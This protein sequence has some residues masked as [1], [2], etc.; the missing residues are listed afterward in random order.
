MVEGAMGRVI[1]DGPG[2]GVWNMAVDEALLDALAKVPADRPQAILRFYQWEPATL[3]LGYFQYLAERESHAAS[4]ECPLVR[5]PSGGGAILHDRELTY[6]L[7]VSAGFPQARPSTQLYHAV[8]RSLIRTLKEFGVDARMWTPPP[9]NARHA[10]QDKAHEQPGEPFLCF[11]RRTDGDVVVDEAKIAGSAQR[12][13]LNAVLQHGS[14]L[15][16]RSPHAPELPGIAELTGV[17]LAPREFATQWEQALSAELGCSFS[18]VSLDAETLAA[19]QVLAESKFGT[20]AWNAR[21]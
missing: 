16:E 3:S 18:P 1:F 11:Q 21:R 12:R 7:T 19:A 15:L 17:R 4:R 8:H 2:S 10:V 6:S 14:V 13:R 9:S 5:R 20:A